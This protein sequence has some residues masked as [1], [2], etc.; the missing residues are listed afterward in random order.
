MFVLYI[1]RF[2][3]S[4]F[5]FCFNVSHSRCV[6]WAWE[7]SKVVCPL[8]C[9]ANLPSPPPPFSYSFSVTL[10]TPE[11]LESSNDNCHHYYRA[12]FFEY[13]ERVAPLFPAYAISIYGGNGAPASSPNSDGSIT[14][15]PSSCFFFFLDIFLFLLRK[16]RLLVSCRVCPCKSYSFTSDVPTHLLLFK[17]L[18]HFSSTTALNLPFHHF[19]M[20]VRSNAN[21]ARHYWGVSIACLLSVIKG[22]YVIICQ[23]MGWSIDVCVCLKGRVEVRHGIHVG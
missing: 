8:S 22:H 9:C 3:F 20:P 18:F 16:K 17:P 19:I 14:P 7:G 5:V 23:S 12:S 4:F 11:D 15:L 1:L 21:L 2:F 6:A 10:F 13:T